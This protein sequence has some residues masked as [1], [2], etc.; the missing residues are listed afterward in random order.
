MKFVSYFH[1]CC[2]DVRALTVSVHDIFQLFRTSNQE[3]Q[4]TKVDHL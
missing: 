3:N 1:G 2:F 4:G